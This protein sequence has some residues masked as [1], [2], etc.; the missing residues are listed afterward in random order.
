MTK[1]LVLIGGGHAHMQAL[2]QLDTF[3]ARG[4]HVSVIQPS[5][6]HYYSGM[7]PGMLGGTYLPDE[8]RF[9]TRA[10]VEAK[11]GSFIE[12]TAVRIDPK[13]QYV[14]LGN[15]D[16]GLYYDVLSCNAGSFVADN[17]LFSPSPSIF[18]AK[19]IEALAK[20]QTAI[21]NGLQS[22]DI[23]IAV[24]GGG[25]SSAEI[26]GN[27]HQLCKD[28]PGRAQITLFGGRTFF[29]GKP[30]KVARSV[31]KI[32]HKKGVRIIEGERVQSIEE[33]KILL[34]GGAHHHADI[35]FC[36]IGVQPSAIFARSGIATGASGG[37]PVNGFLQSLAYPNIFGGGDCI[38]F[39][40][41]PLEKVGVYAVRQNP[42]LTH[43]LMAYL[44]D[45]PLQLFKPGGDYLLIFNLGSGDGVLSK[46]SMTIAGSS[47][48]TIKDYIDRKF[49]RTY[50]YSS[51]VGA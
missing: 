15:S 29:A 4:H 3:V 24:V 47:A 41:Q 5:R 20:A 46:W 19:P 16:E 32:L 26:A 21:L 36:A 43:N 34:E 50:Q 14:Y 27:V 49:M 7:G 30:A 40:P 39:T 33:G 1:Q 12:D 17:N 35:I 28:G 25:P 18:R 10:I 44:E 6:Y 23:T 2:D 11:G 8:I 13:K 31:R 45:R 38:D 37:L 9:D 48:F 22:S 42:T 51:R